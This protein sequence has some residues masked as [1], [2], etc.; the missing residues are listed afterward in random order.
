MT[1]ITLSKTWTKVDNI[2]DGKTYGIQ[3]LGD[4]ECEYICSDSEPSADTEGGWLQAKEQMFYKYIA[5]DLYVRENMPNSNIKL[6][7]AEMEEE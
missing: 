6:F 5:N 3:N 2:N 1:V 7:I 4:W